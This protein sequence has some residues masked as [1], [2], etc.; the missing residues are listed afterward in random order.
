MARLLDAFEQF[1]DNSGDVLN[2][3]SV[4][5]FKSNT[6]SPLTTYADSL[7]TIPN[8]NPLLL[9]ASG[10]PVNSSFA[11]GSAKGA[12]RD[13]A[14]V[15]IREVD[16]IGGEAVTGEFEL[17]DLL[18]IYE[19]NEIVKGSDGKFYIS[20]SAANTGNDPVTPSP[21][22]WSE[23]RLIGV[24]N[25]SE[26]YSSGDIIQDSTGNLWKSLV[27]SNT[28]NT[29][30]SGANWEVAIDQTG[31]TS[32]GNTVIPQTGGGTLTALRINEIRDANAGY[33]LPLAN[34]VLVNQT[35]T[36]TLP[37]RYAVGA[38]VTRSGSDTIEADTSDTSI[39]FEGATIIE[40]TSNGVSEWSI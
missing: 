36:I 6:S 19:L 32:L 21:T 10:R 25:S 28:G 15:L 16:P 14:G 17:F 30:V 38:I 23:F 26:T 31:I 40:L 13:S 27:N 9:N 29:P 8:T 35:I 37:L 34:T 11:S 2:G 3:G 24:Y 22:K 5:F 39:T 1:F 7:M 4:E 33:L 20:L 12:L 18:I